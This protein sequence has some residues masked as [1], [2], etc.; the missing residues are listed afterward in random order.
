[1]VK[2]LAVYGVLFLFLDLVAW[3]ALGGDMHVIA[4][5]LSVFIV[6]AFVVLSFRSLAVPDKC[7]V[8]VVPEKISWRTPDNPRRSL[9]PTGSVPLAAVSGFEVIPQQF[10][11]RKGRPLNGEAVRLT[12]TD[13]GAVTLPLW[14][15]ALRRTEPFQ[16]LLARLQS[17]TTQ[18]ANRGSAPDVTA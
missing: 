11:M 3:L 8:E 15:S 1:M 12:L 4:V 16:L 9:T 10:E 14:S 2:G 5:G 17:A 6:V 13:G 7:W 18:H